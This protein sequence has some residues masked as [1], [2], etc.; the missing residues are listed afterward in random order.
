MDDS[1][2][3]LVNSRAPDGDFAKHARRVGQMSTGD[4]LTY[5]EAVAD[6]YAMMLDVTNQL[7]EEWLKKLARSRE[8]SLQ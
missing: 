4:W 8:N 3:L 2:V 5:F 6:S 1:Y 7:H